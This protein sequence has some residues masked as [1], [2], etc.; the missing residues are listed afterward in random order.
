MR[1]RVDYKRFSTTVEAMGKYVKPL[2]YAGP[3]IEFKVTDDGVSSH[4]AVLQYSLTYGGER[5]VC[6]QTLMDPAESSMAYAMELSE[7]LRFVKATK[8]SKPKVLEVVTEGGHVHMD[9]GTVK[10]TLPE[11]ATDDTPFPRV[12]TDTAIRVHP[13]ILYPCAIKALCKVEKPAYKHDSPRA[14]IEVDN[15]SELS[16]VTTDATRLMVYQRMVGV[17]VPP[18][19]MP[20]PFSVVKRLSALASGE[21][22]DM[23]IQTDTVPCIEFGWRSETGH[24]SYNA[25]GLD[26]REYF[27][28]RYASNRLAPPDPVQS[29]GQYRI[30]FESNKELVAA[31][32]A[33]Q[34]DPLARNDRCFLHY[35]DGHMTIDSPN[36]TGSTPIRVWVVD[37]IG[38]E[39][40]LHIDPK[41]LLDYLSAVG[42]DDRIEIA[43]K[44]AIDP[45]I[46]RAHGNPSV[47]YCVGTCNPE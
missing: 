21:T 32:K 39:F 34:P 19:R 38:Q 25:P 37:F 7:L 3:L 2:N 18:V 14:L 10:W 4:T 6:R 17:D 40:K 44:S 41:L 20:I 45:T 46:V 30:I 35:R 9:V 36:D 8:A 5:V 1:F 15:E 43:G 33:V 22:I 27:D 28:W 16:I 29:S 11:R 42:V 47:W 26:D 31:L 12:V 23:N 24:W 13:F